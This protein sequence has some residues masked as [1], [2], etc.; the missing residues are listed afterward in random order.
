MR[1]IKFRAWDKDVEIMVYSDQQYDRYFFEFDG[2]KLKAFGIGEDPGT[3]HEPPQA[4]S[5]E[6]DNLME[7]TGLKD[8]NGKEI[9]EGDIWTR[10]KTICIVKFLYSGWQLE[11]NKGPIQYPYFYSNANKGEIIG[12]ITENPELL[13]EILDE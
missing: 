8:K 5:T 13:E 6:L 12:N 7:S 1:E 9:Y 10:D 2:G 4:Y 3:I 11:Y